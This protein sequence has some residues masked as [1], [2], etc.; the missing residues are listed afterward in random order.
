M[1]GT[2]SSLSCFMGAFRNRRDDSVEIFRLKTTRNST[3]KP[4]STNNNN[5]LIKKLSASARLNSLV[6]YYFIFFSAQ[7]ANDNK[8]FILLPEKIEKIINDIGE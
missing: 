5:I 4:F 6:V 3:V 1:L 7:T 8:L 2:S